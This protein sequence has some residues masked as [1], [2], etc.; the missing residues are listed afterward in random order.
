MSDVAALAVDAIARIEAVPSILEVV[1]RTT[2]MRFAAVARVTADRWI[3]CGVRDEIAFGLVPGGEL[4]IESTICHEIEAHGQPV[5][6]DHVA[7]DPAFCGHPTPAMYGFQSYISVPIR[8]ADGSFFGTLCAIDPLPVKLSAPETLSMFRLY[9]D[10]IGFHLDA[11]ERLAQSEAALLTE[12]QAAE[13]REQFIAVLGHDLRNPLASIDA[14]VRLLRKTPLNEEAERVSSLVQGAVRRMAGLIDNVL[15]LTR[16]RLGGGILVER[17]A[18]ELLAPTL[19]QVVAELRS[20]WPDRAMEV[21]I[22]LA[23]P[24]RCDRTRIGQVLSNL[25]HNA[26]RH[27]SPEQPVRV[28]AATVAGRMTL[29]VTSHG[30]PIPPENL[31]RLFQP[32]FRGAGKSN[33]EGLGLGLYIAAEIARAHGGKLDVS[34][35]PEA[36]RFTFSMPMG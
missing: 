5:V 6:I 34:S 23:G 20:A 30:E 26:L 28:A 10:L 7:E 2:G 9:A 27:G 16:G 33:P 31:G 32:F 1:A 22:D 14:G 35:T 15:D 18:H 13:L 3:A 25:M 36:T 4:A 21:D 24:V 17:D 8:R 11:K 12:R 19:E 29:S